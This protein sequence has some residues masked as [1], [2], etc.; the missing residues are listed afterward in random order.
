MCQAKFEAKKSSTS[1]PTATSITENT[2][3]EA[4]TDTNKATTRS[5]NNRRNKNGSLSEPLE[6]EFLFDWKV[7][8]RFLLFV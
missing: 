5:N 1:E 8:H 6:L 4:D 3:H 2:E 7:F